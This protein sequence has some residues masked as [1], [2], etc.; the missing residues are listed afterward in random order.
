MQS[1]S[2]YIDELD[3]L[4][5]VAS[6]ISPY[7]STASLL[8]SYLLRITSHAAD[9][10]PGYSL[11]AIKSNT[12]DA[13]QSEISRALVMLESLDRVWNAVLCGEQVLFEHVRKN[14]GDDVDRAVA[15]GGK[16]R[17]RG[18]PRQEDEEDYETATSLRYMGGS[19]RRPEEE[20][21]AVLRDSQPI[22]GSKGIRT[23]AQTDRV[24][25]RNIIVL[26]KKQLFSW[27][28]TSF[29]APP[30]ARTVDEVTGERV[31][32]DPPAARSREDDMRELLVE[33]G[34][35]NPDF[36]AKHEQVE[37]T[38]PSETAAYKAAQQQEEEEELAEVNELGLEGEGA[39][40]G[41]QDLE[42]EDLDAEDYDNEVDKETEGGNEEEREHYQS[43]F[44]RKVSA[45]E[46]C[47][48][49]PR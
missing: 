45:Q 14:A 10:I 12:S 1:L 29:D 38:E 5:G 8:I 3:R 23:V 21:Q 49:E 26:G 42:A 16:K 6:N 35:L 40:P 11:A 37:G 31:G 28:R 36:T 2:A 24:R 22:L 25:L 18:A 20:A 7:G 47:P 27:M 32:G 44:D 4:L 19:M 17:K 13:L 39:E 46:L 30:P 43:L 9:G 48:R 15:K 34:N 41:H 33:Q